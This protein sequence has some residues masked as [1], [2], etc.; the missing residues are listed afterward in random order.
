MAD[1]KNKWAQPAAPPPPMFFGKK[2]RDLV[3]QV[4]DE[5]AERIIGQPV[6]YYAISIQDSNFHDLYGEAI[7]KVSF[8]P[9]RIYAY[10]E[11]ESEQTNER[12]GYEYQSSL[13]VH[14][15][16]KRLTDDQQL[17]VRVGDFVQYGDQ[18]YE[19]VRTYNDTRYYFGQVEH[20]FQ[21]TAECVKAREGNFRVID[22]PTRPKPAAPAPRPNIGGISTPQGATGGA[23]GAPTTAKYVVLGSDS[24][25]TQ[26]RVLTAGSGITL[27]DGGANSTITIAAT[28]VSGAS[29][30]GP[31]GSLQ[32]Q[33]G[34]G[35]VSGSANLTFLTGSSRLGVG[36]DSPTHTVTIIGNMSASSDTFVGGNLTVGGTL[37]GGSPLKISGSINIVDSTG[38][39]ITVLGSS[40]LGPDVIS[41]SLGVVTNLTA[42]GHVSAS[43]FYGDG[44]GLTNVATGQATG[45]GPVGALQFVTGSGGISGSAKILYS[46]GS[47][48]MT[49]NAGLVHNRTSIATSYTASVSD[50]ILGVSAVPTSI[51]F[52]ATLFGNGQVVVVKDE[53]GLASSANLITLNPSASQTVDGAPAVGIESPYGAVFLYSNGTNWF[54]Y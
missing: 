42:S 25:L 33:T 14:F 28:N 1:P 40:S 31:I 45:Q 37:V 29:A 4:N 22:T 16:S 43:Y 10:V 7:D 34:S 32:F 3:K 5:L 26:E 41:S 19:I 39:T 12:Y 49:M 44:S 47:N 52:D 30:Q 18:F 27:T 54:V 50:Y 24:V 2:E 23:A 20:K 9:I 36:T 46:S 21:I 15:N 35:G 38:T 51:L 8:P 13:T 17:Y 53:S 6:A 11:V 48:V